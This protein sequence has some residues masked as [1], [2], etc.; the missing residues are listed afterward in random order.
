LKCAQR[1]K[2]TQRGSSYQ[3][4]ATQTGGLG[5]FLAVQRYGDSGLCLRVRRER[6]ATTRV[7]Q[8]LAKL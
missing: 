4:F 5:V 1:K 6:R 2:K 8:V 3:E 7:G